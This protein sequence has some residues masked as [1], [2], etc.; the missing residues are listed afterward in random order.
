METHVF[1]IYEYRKGN[2]ASFVFFRGTSGKTSLLK[3]IRI[4]IYCFAVFLFRAG[5]ILVHVGCIPT[6]NVNRIFLDNVLNMTFAV[7]ANIFIGLPL[8]VGPR[9]W[10]GFFGY[11]QT[12]FSKDIDLLHVI[13]S[14]S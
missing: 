6:D 7:I 13:T 3:N 10:K 1:D 5:Y 2:T 11:G 9:S 12:I 4:L 14:E 8:Y